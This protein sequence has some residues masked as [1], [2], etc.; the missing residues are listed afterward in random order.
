MHEKPFK[1]QL[2]KLQ[3]RKYRDAY[4]LFVVEGEKGVQEAINSRAHVETIFVEEGRE[5]RL[6]VPDHVRVEYIS[7]KTGRAISDTDTFPGVAAVIHMHEPA[8]IDGPVVCLDHISD[9]GNL[10]TIIRTADW[11]GVQHIMLSEGSVDPYNPKVVR[12][13]MGSL[14]RANIHRSDNVQQDL[15]KLIKS[16]YTIAA[17]D[18]KGKPLRELPAGEKTVYLFGSESHG[19]RPELL[20]LATAYTIPGAGEAESLN[21]GVSVGIVLHRAIEGS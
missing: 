16:G 18:M 7:P 5:L 1:K 15:E 21:L 13:T 19:I 6:A 2:L 17:L 11:F 4:G 3:Q 12:S 14:F 8:E 9:P 20:Q 10:G